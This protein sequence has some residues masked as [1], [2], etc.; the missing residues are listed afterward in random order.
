MFTNHIISR[1]QQRSIMQN[2][3]GLVYEFGTATDEGAILTMKDISEAERQAKE[4]INRLH[5][6]K[7]VFVAA[8]GDVMITTYRATKNQRRRIVQ[9][10]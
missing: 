2:D 10:N 9:S 8:D 3:L 7:N 4:L 6:L 5:K 1:A